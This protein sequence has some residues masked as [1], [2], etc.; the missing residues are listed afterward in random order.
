MAF[1]SGRG[2]ELFERS[3]YFVGL[4]LA[5][6]YVINFSVAVYFNFLIFFL[7]IL[8][9]F[10]QSM[11]CCILWTEFISRC[12]LCYFKEGICK[13]SYMFFVIKVFLRDQCGFARFLLALLRYF[14]IEFLVFI[15]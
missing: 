13:M 7:R 15:S 14:S 2:L 12:F 5:F 11:V 10:L 1:L 4:G 3:S 9:A 8:I 6:L